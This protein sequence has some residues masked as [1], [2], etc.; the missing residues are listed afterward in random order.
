LKQAFAMAPASKAA[1]ESL[2]EIKR[3]Y[4]E[5]TEVCPHLSGLS[6]SHC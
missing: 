6:F 3:S 1:R 4:K 5:Y 2:T